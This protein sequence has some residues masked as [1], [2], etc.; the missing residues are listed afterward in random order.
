[1]HVVGLAIDREI[2]RDETIQMDSQ[3]WITKDFGWIWMMDRQDIGRC[4]AANYAPGL[5]VVDS[6][7]Q[8]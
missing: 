1:M 5:G 7:N 2:D 6:E 8:N 3:R 4:R